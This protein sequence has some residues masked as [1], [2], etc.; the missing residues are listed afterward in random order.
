M[1]ILGIHKDPWHNTGGLFLKNKK[2]EI[3]TLSEERL[4][5]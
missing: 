3:F 1:I 4:T 5:E 2:L